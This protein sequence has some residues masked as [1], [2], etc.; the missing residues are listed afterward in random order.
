[1]GGHDNHG[2]NGDHHHASKRIQESDQ[3]IVSKIRPIEL[4]KHNP[5][6]FHVNVFDLAAVEDLMG[7]TSWFL[8]GTAGAA[9]SY[10]YYA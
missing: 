8:S 10:W 2:H 1:M 7:G 9:F 5:N 6:L 3:E 4:I